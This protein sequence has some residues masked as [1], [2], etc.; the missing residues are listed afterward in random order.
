MTRL[1]PYP[2]PSAHAGDDSVDAGTIAGLPGPPGLPLLGNAHQLLRSTRIHLVAEEWARR[3]GPIVRINVGRQL[4][5]AVADADAINEILRDRPEGFRRWR[6][7]RAVIEEMNGSG[8]FIAEGEE[9]KRQRRLVVTAL[10]THYV[11]RYFDVIRTSTERLRRRLLE[12]AGDRR[13]LEIC[14]ELTSFTVDVTSALALGTDLNTLERRDNEL[15]GHIQRVLRMTS[16]RI[17]APVPYWRWLRLPADRA[18][19]HSVLEVERAVDVFIEQARARMDADP[20]RFKEPS[21]LLEGMLAAQAADRTFSDREIAG[22]VFTIL[23]AGEDTTAN[24]LAW[25]IWLLASRP[26][27][28]ARLATEASQVLDDGSVPVDHESTERLVYAE[29][30]LRESM[31]LKP[32]IPVLPVEPI[33]ETTICGTRIPAKT[34]LLLLTRQATRTAASRSD[35]FHP[36]RW[37][38]DGDDTRAPKSLAFGAGPRFC[39]GRNLAFLEAKT[40]LA[41]I[42]RDFELELDASAGQ[43]EE[44]L[45]FAMVPEGLRVRLRER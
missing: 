3:Y 11:H 30:V 42:A 19:E 25:T 41:M 20:R 18:L 29:A 2:L 27:I 12:A 6:D 5:I 4:I 28:Q 13:S 31:R 1:G 37:L 24:T 44:T 8:V 16:R 10:N 7:Q 32:V 23:L 38:P 34:R 17:A 39:P 35:E 22:N 33:E 14:D 43:V 9:W 40:A 26:E 45:K 15:Q 21:N 36:E